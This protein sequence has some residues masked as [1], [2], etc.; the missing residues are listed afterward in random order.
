MEVRYLRVGFRWEEGRR[1]KE[2]T[3]LM[4]YEESAFELE[5]FMNRIKR[6]KSADDALNLT[7]LQ[8]QETIENV[9]M[10]VVRR[11]SISLNLYYY[12]SRHRY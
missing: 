12:Q 6:L 3:A 10:T 2:L 9:V 1:A 8:Q 11:I 7:P 4:K 5:Q